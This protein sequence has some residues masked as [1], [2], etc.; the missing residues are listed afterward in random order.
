MP[1]EISLISGFSGSDSK[2]VD[3]FLQKLIPHLVESEYLIVGGLAIRYQLHKHGVSYPIGDFNDLDLKANS[4]HAVKPSVTKDFLIYH[5]HPLK[6]RS[7]FIVLVDP[8]TKIK[9][10]VFDRTIKE[11]GF[12]EIVF[13]GSKIKVVNIE[14]QLVKTVFDIQRIS[15]ENKVDPKQFIDTRLLL[16][17]ADMEKANEIWRDRE[18][19]QYPTTIHEAIDRAEQIYKEHPEWV[20]EK[21]FRHLE[22]YVCPKCESVSGFPITPM[23]EIYK[24]L[25]YTE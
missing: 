11:E 16:K 23:E 19:R 6:N 1:K 18:Y 8:E 12:E 14:D 9:I 7:F 5:Y 21:P 22:P 3:K 4:P 25:G 20:V 17:V 24:I 10:D 15:Q 2:M 13:H